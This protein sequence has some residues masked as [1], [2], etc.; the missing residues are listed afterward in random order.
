[1]NLLPLLEV[2][3][4]VKGKPE[5]MGLLRGELRMWKG[6]CPAPADSE[7]AREFT[8]ELEAALLR[9]ETAESM[10]AFLAGERRRVSPAVSYPRQEE[11]IHS[12]GASELGCYIPPPPYEL[13]Q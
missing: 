3:C 5:A 11:K 9:L 1:M 2:I 12:E 7:Y 13:E 4:Q 10:D 6:G 8:Q